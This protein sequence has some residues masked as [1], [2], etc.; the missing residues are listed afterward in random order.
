M[1]PATCYADFR[2]RL[3]AAGDI[4]SCRC[5]ACARISDLDLKFVVHAGGFVLQH[6]AGREE[7][8]GPEVVLAHRLLK[9]GAAGRLGQPAYALVTDAAARVLEVPAAEVRAARRAGRP[10]RIGPGAG[11]PL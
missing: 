10:L 3:L 7:L 11:P 4:W 8:V 5:D 9:N 1:L 2:G 6:I